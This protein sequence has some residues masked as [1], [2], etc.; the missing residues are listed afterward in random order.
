MIKKWSI[1]AVEYARN[2]KVKVGLVF[3]AIVVLITGFIVS[4][5]YKTPT[6]IPPVKTGVPQLGYTG[7]TPPGGLREDMDTFTPTAFNF[8]A[9]PDVNS[10]SVIT[11]PY[12]ALKITVYPESPNTL[13]VEPLQKGWESNTEY[14]ITIKALKG[15]SGEELKSPVE[16]SF[17]NQ[18]PE[19]VD[20][21]GPL[22]F[23]KLP[24][25]N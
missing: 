12:L 11:S 22:D 6:S 23:S 7:A 14:K 9:P 5:Q 13:V 16:Y 24:P 4:S 10:A 20:L 3:L 15:L 21:E 18:P 1:Y 19:Y 8:S 17:T 2:H 25:I